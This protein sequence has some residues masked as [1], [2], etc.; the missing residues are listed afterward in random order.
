MFFVQ[1]DQTANNLQRQGALQ[2]GRGG[3]SPLAGHGPWS[4]HSYPLW[5]QIL[6]VSGHMILENININSTKTG[7]TFT[8]SIWSVIQVT[9]L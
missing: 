7:Q 4:S 8:V 5:H 1:N 6:S 3:D 9:S 2:K